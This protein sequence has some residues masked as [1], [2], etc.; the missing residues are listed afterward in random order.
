MRWYLVR[1]QL[2]EIFEKSLMILA[3]VADAAILLRLAFCAISLRVVRIV[4]VLQLDVRGQAALLRRVLVNGLLSRVEGRRVGLLRR[5]RETAV[6]DC[7]CDIDI[8]GSVRGRRLD[9]DL[10]RVRKSLLFATGARRQFVGFFAYQV[11]GQHWRRTGT[12]LREVLLRKG[13]LLAALTRS[14][15]LQL[16]YIC[17]AD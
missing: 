1:R 4:H 10:H 13:H 6:I 14:V 15:Q 9:G 11:G 8:I 16:G 2:D 12:V 3:L 17:L 7:S 5:L